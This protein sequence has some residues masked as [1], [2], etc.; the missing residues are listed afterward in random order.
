MPYCDLLPSAAAVAAALLYAPYTKDPT[1]EE[2]CRVFVRARGIQA[3]SGLAG[4]LGVVALADGERIERPQPR[5]Q[6]D[7]GEPQS[8][9]ADP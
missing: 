3:F 2:A 8:R 4:R 1:A 9:T 6:K 5:R 7:G